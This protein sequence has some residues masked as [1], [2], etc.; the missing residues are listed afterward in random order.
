M[1]PWRNSR[2]QKYQSRV[3]QRV[4][5]S[6][7]MEFSYPFG[8]EILEPFSQAAR[9]YRTKGRGSYHEKIRNHQNEQYNNYSSQYPEEDHYNHD[10]RQHHKQ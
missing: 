3:N 10:Y 9:N 7:V 5:E 6:D 4:D 2:Q 1:D 8:Q